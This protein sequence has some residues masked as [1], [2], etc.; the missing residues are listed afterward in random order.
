MSL[1]G[2]GSQKKPSIRKTTKEDIINSTC[3]RT[4]FKARTTKKL[5]GK[6]KRENKEI[7]V[8]SENNVG[9]VSLQKPKLIS[10]QQSQQQQQQNSH[11]VYIADVWQY[12]FKEYDLSLQDAVNLSLTCKRFSKMAVEVYW[13]MVNN[14]QKCLYPFHKNN[15]ESGNQISH[16]NNMCLFR[17]DE[18]NLKDKSSKMKDIYYTTLSNVMKNYHH[19]YCVNCKCIIQ[20]PTCVRNK[21]YFFHTLTDATR[22]KNQITNKKQIIITTTT[23]KNGKSQNTNNGGK[24][25]QNL[26]SYKKHGH[27]VNVMCLNCSNNGVVKRFLKHNKKNI[28]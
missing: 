3:D 20:C 15:N 1:F 21:D 26:T 5:N 19:Y 2:K 23:T 16:N 9:V 22:L 27:S 10:K 17:S 4:T 7:V 12:L 6:R 14:T 25:K 28:N 18:Y 8:K 13:K 24:T 11:V